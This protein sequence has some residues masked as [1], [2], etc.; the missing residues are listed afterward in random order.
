MSGFDLS[1][2]IA[3]F[4]DEA[5]ERLSS[6]NQELV[7]FEAGNLSDEG[8]NDLRRDAHTI[9]GSALM[10]GVTDVGEVAHHFED[11]VEALRDHAEWRQPAAIQ[12]LFDV[13]DALAT[14]LDDIEGKHLLDSKAM[15]QQYQAVRAALV[16]D[17]S[18]N[19][20]TTQEVDAALSLERE[21]LALDA[22]ANGEEVE[23]TLL[24]QRTDDVYDINSA[25][26]SEHFIANLAPEKASEFRPT[27]VNNDKKSSGQRKSS[28]CFLRVDA[29]RLEGLSHQVIEMSTEQS[30]SAKAETDLQAAHL[31]FRSLHREWRKIRY[32]LEASDYSAQ[33]I[34]AMDEMYETQLR[35]MRHLAQEMRYQSERNMYALKE[36]RD[37]VLSLMLRPLDSIFSMFPRAVRDA[38]SKIGKNVQLLVDG[39]SVEMDQNVAD[40][41]VEPLIH[42]LTNAVAHGIEDESTRKANGKPAQGQVSI[43]A[44]QSGSEVHIEVS[45]DGRGID[46]EMIRKVAVKRGVTTADEANI[47]SQAEILELIFR[48]GFSTLDVVGQMAGRGIGMN[49]VQTA[50]RKLTGN[51]RIQ[52]VVGQGTKFI[53]SVP[54]SVAVQQALMFKMGSQRY[55]ILTHMV[56]QVVPYQKQQVAYSNTGKAYFIYGQHHVPLVDLRRTLTANAS[57]LAENPYII[58]AEHIEGFVGIVVDELLGDGEIVV[59]DLDPYLKRYQPQGLMGNTITDDGSVV[60]LLE[61]YGIKEMG[62]TSPVQDIDVQIADEDKYYFKVLLVDDSLIA[63]EVEKRMFE[64]LGFVVETAIDGMDGLEKLAASEFDMVV[65]DLEMPRLD[66]FGFVRQL[67]NQPK[68]EEMPLMVIST[69]ESTEDRMRALDSGADAYMV[70][71]YLTA[72]SIISTVKALVGPMMVNE[73]GVKHESQV[74]E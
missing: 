53:I 27:V 30:Q 11:M 44:I 36:L 12:F 34:Q 33:S 48:P 70:K 61:P 9:K 49:V 66:G 67:R 26:G 50:I 47:M 31:D 22:Q 73:R 54:I 2:F 17:A 57:P 8:L 43:V 1:N 28:G 45:D 59:H 6:I 58:I 74:P 25:G 55:C 13:H 42:L 5:K 23:D 39:E 40:S 63:R 3:S 18:N 10:L 46:T 37:H 68:Y 4:F 29:E 38:A 15:G 32:T 24:E 52:T 20:H 19:Q 71:Q 62:R 65:T 14:R 7:L 72:E 41:L 64:N 69:R 60:M 56:E 51:I 21:V 35:Q 16:S